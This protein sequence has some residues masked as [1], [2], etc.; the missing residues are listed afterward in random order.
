MA[1]ETAAH[2]QLAVSPD[3]TQTAHAFAACP[4]ESRFVQHTPFVIVTESGREQ[5]RYGDAH[6]PRREVH[7]QVAVAV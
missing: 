7:R 4:V 2:S 6:V 1:R 5:R 3:E